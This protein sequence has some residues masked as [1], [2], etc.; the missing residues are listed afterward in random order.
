M[1]MSEQSGLKPWLDRGWKV[2]EGEEHVLARLQG[3]PLGQTVLLILLGPKNRFGARYFQ[4]FLRSDRGQP[5]DQSM[6]LGLYSSGRYPSYNWIE[7][8]SFSSC[9]S[10]GGDNAAELC[11][12]LDGLASE[13]FQYL[14]DLLPRGGHMMIE[15]DSPE[16]EGTRRSLALGIPPA[17]TP[18]GFLLFSVGCG[19]GFKDWHFAEGGS[20]GP[21]KLQGYKALN[22]EDA[23]LKARELEQELESFLKRPAKEGRSDLQESARKRAL[24]ILR[25]L[26]L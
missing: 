3:R 15:Y 9:V 14:A 4:I 17:A 25:K 8:I 23:F 18:L 11:V 7:V 19:A 20:E 21:R 13:L 5:S 1:T 22:S 24:D 12:Y 16:H 10:F 6:I 2:V 26:K